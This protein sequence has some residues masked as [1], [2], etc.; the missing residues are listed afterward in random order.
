MHVVPPLIFTAHT[1]IEVILTN[2]M[3][4]AGPLVYV[5]L[6]NRAALLQA[7]NGAIFVL[8]SGL[9]LVAILPETVS[10]GGWISLLFAL[11]GLIGPTLGEGMFHRAA[12]QFH[13]LALIAG[14]VGLVVHSAVDGAALSGSG[15]LS[16][17]GEVRGAGYL[18]LAVILHR[19]P[20]GLLLWWLLRPRY[21]RGL[22]WG[23]LISMATATTLGYGAG[24]EFAELLSSRQ[25]AWFKAFAA[26]AVLHIIV[27]PD[28]FH[29]PANPPA[30]GEV[31]A[32]RPRGWIE[33][34]GSVAG[35]LMLVWLLWSDDD[36]HGAG[37]G[38]VMDAFVMLA[39]ESAPALLFAYLAA[40]LIRVFLPDSWIDWM[41][42]GSRPGQAV[43]GMV[44]GLP[45]PICSCG[46]L[47]VYQSLV[48]RRVPPT[49]GLSFLIATPELGIAAL[50][51]SIPLLGLEMT[52]VRVLGA[53]ALAVFV[54][55][56]L[57]RLAGRGPRADAMPAGC[58]AHDNEPAHEHDH[59][60]EHASEAEDC[61][62]ITTA[63]TPPQTAFAERL[64]VSLHEGLVEF[65]DRTAPWILLG[66]AV[67]AVL[68]AYWDPNWLAG[69]P[70][71]L[72]VLLWAALGLPFYVC[73]S[74]ATPLVAV[75]LLHG[76]SP[77]AALAFLLTGPAT[78]I[79]TFGVLGGLHGRQFAALF[80]VVTTGGAVALGYL[81]NLLASEDVVA[82][83]IK[84]ELHAPTSFQ[85][86]SLVLLGLLFLASLGRRGG[87]AFVGEVLNPHGAHS[88]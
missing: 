58:H 32:Y 45:L 50:L 85:A 1:L 49:A 68:H 40:G 88:H 31:E 67:A 69:M 81:V 83:V 57:G 16:E 63:A 42:R 25:F 41:G 43:R 86:I 60:H 53:M 29:F 70:D 21:G 46:V 48:V 17:I 76:V 82:G 9:V 27:N 51:L 78:N 8:V 30:R 22:A 80:G 10:Y 55:V 4:L 2:L 66:M 56:V 59:S 6:T 61:C 52:L 71:A 37:L 65:V 20:V 14:I 79:A 38:E 84:P 23:V 54:A 15:P 18:S 39:I 72:E 34:I 5:W 11:A 33:G 87:R 7:M 75:L 44:M 28:H 62:N 73:A 26:G 12:H 19:L 74:G 64:R 77:G 36:H 3:L 47:P 24:Q 35:L 13:L